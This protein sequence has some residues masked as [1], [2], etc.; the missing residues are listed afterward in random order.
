MGTKS[1]FLPDVTEPS[2]QLA[3]S[4]E[5]ELPW[6]TPTDQDP[7]IGTP[8]WAFPAQAPMFNLSTKKTAAR[9]IPCRHQSVNCAC[10][11]SKTPK[12]SRSAPRIYGQRRLN[13]AEPPSSGEGAPRLLYFSRTRSC[14]RRRR[15]SGLW[16]VGWRLPTL[17]PVE[18][19]TRPPGPTPAAELTALSV[20]AWPLSALS[21]SAPAIV[22]IVTLTAHARAP[23]GSCAWFAAAS[24]GPASTACE[25]PAENARSLFQVSARASR[26]CRFAPQS[27]LWSGSIGLHQRAHRRT[28]PFRRL[29]CRSISFKLDG[30]AE[31]RP[32]PCADRQ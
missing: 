24:T 15:R 16:C 2:F 13:C 22:T 11:L 20:H 19:S 3:N 31:S 1:S 26:P 8:R 21:P 5:R 9:E 6:L 7:S 23:C 17:R 32:S 4:Q 28:R 30:P 27:P 18:L 29:A 10:F 25:C 14:C 12:P